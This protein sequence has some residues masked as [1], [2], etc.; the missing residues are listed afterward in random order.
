MIFP[1]LN[2]VVGNKRRIGDAAMF[3]TA[4]WSPYMHRYPKSCCLWNVHT[5]CLF[6]SIYCHRHPY[7]PFRFLWIFS[8]FFFIYIYT[9]HH[10]YCIFWDF[11]VSRPVN[12]WVRKRKGSE[13]GLKRIPKEKRS[14]QRP[15]GHLCGLHVLWETTVNMT[16][17]HMTAHTNLWSP[18]GGEVRFICNTQVK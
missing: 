12:K 13:K 8:V 9:V 16:S 5:V 2:Y 11:F 18:V 1:T 10:M 7:D 4:L 3:L 6:H 17:K 14:S 15:H